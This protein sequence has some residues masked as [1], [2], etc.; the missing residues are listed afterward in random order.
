[1]KKAFV[2][3]SVLFLS[4]AVVAQNG[5]QATAQKKAE[6]Y[7]TFKELKHDFGKIK[8]N[9]PVTYDFTFV[10]SSSQPIVI[11]YASASCGCTTP[12]WPQ[13]AVGKGKSDKITA[14]FNAQAPGPFNKSITVKV[15][16]VATPLT[17]N[18]VGEVL[19]PEDYA[20]YKSSKSGK[21][22]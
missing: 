15:A 8:Q 17:L 11:E 13:G 6:D 9:Q 20:K 19:S 14:G 21:G 4:V 2:A 12:T 7:V 16:G 10:N 1:M 3:L 18:I 22:K 5:T